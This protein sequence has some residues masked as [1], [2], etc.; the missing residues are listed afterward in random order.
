[1]GENVKYNGKNNRI[2]LEKLK[3]RYEL[4]PF[5]PEVEEKYNGIIIGGNSVIEK[6]L[7]TPKG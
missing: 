4:I 2:S 6:S 3:E 5:C 7:K 1:M